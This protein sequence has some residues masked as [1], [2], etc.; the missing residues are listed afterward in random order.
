MKIAEKRNKRERLNNLNSCKVKQ[1]LYTPR[2]RFGGEE[3]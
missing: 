2:R 1:S 3:V